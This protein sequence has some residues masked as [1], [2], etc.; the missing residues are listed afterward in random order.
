MSR[1]KNFISLAE[2]NPELVVE[3]HPTRNGDLTP[4]DISYGSAKK[5]W[6]LGKCGH[7]WE[8]SLNHRSR[9]RGCP[10]CAQVSR[11]ISHSKNW[12][13]KYG[14]LADNNPELAK[15]WHPTLNGNLTPH[16]V[17]V[18]SSKRV[19]WQCTKGHDW[20]AP[21]NSR[22]SGVGCPVCS[23][24]RLVVGVNDLAT[25]RPDLAAQWHSIKNKDLRPTDVI[26]GTDTIIWWQCEK[27]HEW[28]ARIINRINGNNCPV[29]IGKKVLAGYNDLATVAPSLAKEWH[30]TLN[31]DLRPDSIVSGSNKK[32]W[33]RCEK[34]HE[35]QTAPCL[36]IKGTAC[37]VCASEMK[38]SF[39]EQAIFFYLKQITVAYN[40]Y[41]L[42]S[43]TE[44]D[45]YL[46]EYKLG[47]EYDGLYYHKG[48][49]ARQREISK[50][51]RLKKEGISLIRVK[52]SENN[53]N[54]M[55]MDAFIY[56]KPYY[57]DNDLCK[58]I[59]DL[60]R[61]IENLTNLSFELD[62]D[63]ARDRYMIYNQY[64]IGEKEKSLLILQP[65]LAEQWHPTKNGDL[66][67]ENVTASANKKIWW[68][69]EQGHEWQAMLNSRSQGAGCPIC[70]GKQV[71]SG[72][73][74]LET[75]NPNIAKQWHPT[76]NGSM[77]PS[78]IFPSSNKKFW[79]M[80]EKGHEWQA[81]AAD[82]IA[83]KGCAVCSG[84]KVLTGYNDLATVNP[85]LAS[86]WHPTK[87]GAL[88]PT[89]ITS[90]TDRRVW[91]ICEKGHEWDA[92]VSS[93]TSG[94]GC[95][96]CAG[97]RLIKGINDLLSLNPTLAKQWHPT[98][99]GNLSPSDVM[100][101]S[102]KKAWWLGECGHEWEAV[103]S[104]RNAGRGC[105]YC[106]SVKL[107]V[108]YNDLATKNPELAKEWHPTKNGDKTPKDFI[109]GSNKKAWWI[110][111]KGH[112]WQNSI[113]ARNSGHKCP[114]CANQLLLVG[115]NDLATLNP[116]LAKQWHPIKNGDK[117]PQDFISGSD[118]KVWWLCG[119]GHEWQAQINSR[120][121]GS[122]CPECYRLK[123]KSK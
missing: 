65:K 3:W 115:Y 42:D 53:S 104:T 116:E 47:I 20:D 107:L 56:S 16:D 33:W 1:G 99:N 93:R 78:D 21:I 122:G 108:G 11:N 62:I 119:Q 96:Y 80:C 32:V 109:S 8:Q 121:K 9:G 13:A 66:L 58:T 43:R 19:Y 23:G 90:G 2:H 101:N 71:L 63:V 54:D 87:N 15:Q 49:K 89:D 111:E 98:K 55:I 92:V 45:I 114:Y 95:P 59:S 113:G 106:S 29:C 50:Y 73:N 68:I 12:I 26:A 91:W 52:E 31:G 74:D 120:N 36:R 10:I 86:Q 48:E 76:K 28:K 6:W 46:P 5:V 61:C 25:V 40:R 57:R 44:I 102:N 27:G 64:I 88:M 35:W 83:G 112:E 117:T 123:R 22:N 75:K 18:N 103:I 72:F 85:Q 82:R 39:P 60:M 69:C 24:H 38:T 118:K 51:N 30:P 4:N 17:T 77:T 94:I 84:H 14:S 105:P 34:G 97:Q 81:T 110:C 70:A 100:P 7:E 41:K 37:P 79:W 67:P